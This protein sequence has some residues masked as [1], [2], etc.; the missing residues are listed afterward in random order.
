MIRQTS[1]AWRLL[2]ALAAVL[3]LLGGVFFLRQGSIQADAKET[4]GKFTEELVYVRSDDGFTHAGAIF[5]P[6]KESA[7]RTA[8]IWIHGSGVNFYYPTYV[9]ICRSLAERGYT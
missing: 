9:R 3:A 5:A 4:A 2:T 7:K 6:P 8:V 1:P